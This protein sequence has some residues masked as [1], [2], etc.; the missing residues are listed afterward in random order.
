PQIPDAGRRAV[1]RTWCVDIAVTI[2]G[3]GRNR[4]G[5]V[6]GRLRKLGRVDRLAVAGPP[7]LAIEQATLEPL[8]RLRPIARH[9]G[10]FGEAL[11]RGTGDKN[12]RQMGPSHGYSSYF[13]S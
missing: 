12:G 1:A 11:D 7:V 6:G 10:R 9:L 5:L 2:V 13:A 3:H 4:R 8:H